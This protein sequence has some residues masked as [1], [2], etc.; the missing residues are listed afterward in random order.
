[1]SVLSD[2]KNIIT[3]TGSNVYLLDEKVKEII[4]STP[5]NISIEKL[6]CS[7][8]EYDRIYE[9][10][11][12]LDLFSTDKLLILRRF[13][14]NKELI[15]H[16]QNILNSSPNST[17]IL[18]VDSDFDKRSTIYKW[19]KKETRF[20]EIN[21]LSP[22]ELIDWI[23]EKAQSLGGTID[24][25]SAN[26]LVDYCGNNQERISNEISKLVNY[27]AHITKET[28]KTLVDPLI[29]TT[30]FQL[31]DA[32]FSGNKEEAIRVY[33]EQRN[34][35]VE[36]QQIIAML[37]WQLQTLALIKLAKGNTMDEIARET[38]LSPYVVKKN[39]T[40]ARRLSYENLKK[41]IK[42]LLELD[43]SLK[44]KSVDSDD[45][46]KTLILSITDR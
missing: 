38:N 1:M 12:N 46:L 39:S 36:P 11:V 19:L 7:E 18:I 31:I 16:A 2:M 8:V 26:Y 42:N 41:L 43:L 14:K 30:I 44:T 15:N 21:E 3:L 17:Q 34:Q 33:D 37:T 10:I 13:S 24:N 9:S 5:N 20:D 35:K 45:A 40:I 29:Q 6:D 4:N 23:K 32:A 25:V 22:N 27:D 28:I